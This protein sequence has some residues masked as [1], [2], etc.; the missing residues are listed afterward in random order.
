MK[1]WNIKHSLLTAIAVS[2]L[3]SVA[4]F[5]IT[6]KPAFA[7]P[8]ITLSP[9]SGSI[10]TEVTVS[11]TDF[12]SF[13]NT[14]LVIMFDGV[15]IESSPLTV[16]VSGD[17]TTN[18]AVPDDAEEGTAYVT[19][20]TILGGEIRKSFLVIGP[21]IEINTDEGPVGTEVEIEGDG[22]YAGGEVDI[23]YHSRDSKVNMATEPTS[24]EGS[25]SYT[26]TIPES[27]AGVHRI[28]V[29]DELGNSAEADFEVLP[30][31]VLSAYSGAVENNL[32]VS[33]SGFAGLSEVE[34][35]F[36]GFDAATDTT[37][38]YGSFKVTFKVPVLESGSYAV[39]AEDED[40]NWTKAAFNLSAGISLN[41]SHGEV[42]TPLIVRGVGFN[43]A[44]LITVTYD[45]TE[46]A[47]TVSDE[48]GSFSAAFN[49]PA[50]SGGNHTITVTDGIHTAQAIFTMESE[51]PPVPE[52]I[53]PED[54]DKA[55]ALTRFEWE[56]SP[57]PSGVTYTLQVA[58]SEG[59]TP[60]SIVLEKD[61]LEEPGYSLTEEEELSPSTK[62]APHYWRV[63]ATDSA[64]NSS[65]WSEPA[66]FY[67]SSSFV[68]SPTV[69]NVLIGIGV[70]AAVFFGFWLGGRTAYKR[71]RNY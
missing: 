48:S 49:V 41:Q 69:R 46:V 39:E 9:A 5:T 43:A 18:F 23:Y 38:K 55:E 28:T 24:K 6:A 68:I 42:G 32:T 67:V 36:G 21:E 65:E 20:K 29:E 31:I 34:V 2:A 57:D 4:A 11:G 61:G 25:F 60:A 15:E 13:K 40:G 8:E 3:L 19:V 27:A 51:A 56:E 10:G 52:L 33:G 14:G 44:V 62:E 7:Q 16:P 64:G 70:G 71:Q 66:S 45:N 63:K 35:I 53:F 47:T 59:F 26:L 1:I 54:G 17:F 30:S 58:E 37:S 12:N 22:F 50:S